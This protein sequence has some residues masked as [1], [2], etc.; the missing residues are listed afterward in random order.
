MIQSSANRT[1]KLLRHVIQSLPTPSEAS[2]RQNTANDRPSSAP[3]RNIPPS[4]T[5][6][7]STS[8]VPSRQ[9]ALPSQS[10]DMSS[11]ESMTDANVLQPTAP[12]SITLQRRTSAQ[13]DGSGPRPITAIDRIA[14]L[15]SQ[16]IRSHSP[17]SVDSSQ[18]PVAS[19]KDKEMATQN[20]DAFDYQA[21]VNALTIQFLSKHEETR[22]AALKWLI[23]LHQK[24][25][26]KVRRTTLD[27][28]FVC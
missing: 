2:S 12:S 9:S 4:P 27:I 10:R 13:P 7:A 28:S 25:P 6:G 19:E 26:T 24:V 5:P 3:S 14:T 11:P 21:T 15:Q 22:V 16:G 18:Q 8:P 23:M 20:P 17:T 1:N